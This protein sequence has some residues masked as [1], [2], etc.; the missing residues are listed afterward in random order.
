MAFSSLYSVTHAFQVKM[1]KILRTFDNFHS[2][3]KNGVQDRCSRDMRILIGRD[4]AS[5]DT[6]KNKF[7]NSEVKT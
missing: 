1:Y 6:Q 3:S 4:E 7:Y 2:T 5:F